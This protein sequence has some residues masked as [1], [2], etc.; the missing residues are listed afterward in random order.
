[1]LTFFTC[2][3]DSSSYPY[4]NYHIQSSFANNTVYILF[5]SRISVTLKSLL[6]NFLSLIILT[7][8]IRL[9]L[10]EV[11]LEEL[12]ILVGQ[13]F[14]EFYAKRNQPCPIVLEYWPIKLRVI[15][16][17]N[18]NND[19]IHQ[20]LLLIHINTSNNIF[21]TVSSSSYY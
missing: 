14:V 4:T 18:I 13:F 15:P 17:H 6:I 2:N 8:I 3:I 9:Q 21:L 16:F 19:L 5:F 20:Q 11:C 12:D 7:S 1:M 10:I